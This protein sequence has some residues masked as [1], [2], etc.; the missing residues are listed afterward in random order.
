MAEAFDQATSVCSHCDKI[1]PFSNIDLHNAH[2]SRNLVK[3]KIC[4]DMVPGK[5]IEKHFLGTH[6][7]KSCSQCND[8]IERKKIGEHKGK[9]C[10]QRIVKCDYCD[11]PLPAAGLSKHQEVCGSRTK[12][13]YSCRI[14]VRLREIVNHE[15]SCSG[16]LNVPAESS[17]DSQGTD[18][19]TSVCSHCDKIIPFSNLD[20]H[21]AHCS[22]NLV[23]CKICG[24]MVPSKL[25]EKHVHFLGT[26]AT[27]PEFSPNCLLISIAVA[28]ITILLG[29][30]FIGR[31]GDSSPADHD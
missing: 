13:C 10:L 27:I 25:I 21:Y 5:L 12:L 6:A 17:R 19:A 3:C 14:Y 4:G 11:F 22:R 2:C 23:K 9:Y 24:D 18:Q 31:N 16:V 7:T 26:R 20:S 29:S 1:I 8:T 15:S 30:V 28:G